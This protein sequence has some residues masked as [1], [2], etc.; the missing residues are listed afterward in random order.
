MQDMTE[1]IEKPIFKTPKEYI[2]SLV[3]NE[4]DY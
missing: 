1:F 3:K 4:E 2:K